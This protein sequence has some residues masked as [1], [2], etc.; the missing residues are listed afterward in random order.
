MSAIRNQLRVK[1]QPKQKVPGQFNN[2]MEPQ[3]AQMASGNKGLADDSGK[4]AQTKK[5]MGKK[6]AS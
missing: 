5:P 3:Q 1:G 2:A 6:K 4:P